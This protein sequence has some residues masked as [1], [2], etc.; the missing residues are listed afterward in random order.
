MRDHIFRRIWWV[1][2]GMGMLMPSITLGA[3]AY[4]PPSSRLWFYSQN[5]F[6]SRTDNFISQDKMKY[7]IASLGSETQLYTGAYMTKDTRTDTNLIYNDNYV[8]PLFGLGWRSPHLRMGAFIDLMYAFRTHSSKLDFRAAVYHY[9]FRLLGDSTWDSLTQWFFE[10][11]TDFSHLHNF[12]NNA[13]LQHWSKV[14]RRWYLTSAKHWR[15]D[16]FP[17]F[18]L[19]KDLQSWPY[20]SFVDVRVGLR[21]EYVFSSNLASMTVTRGTGLYAGD[22]YF[23][24]PF[25]ILLVLG[26]GLD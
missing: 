4:Q 26:L 21:L 19:N 20:S 9:D 3:D 18:I 5:L 10:T 17:E 14:G 8:A 15:A 6:D 13:F 2:A 1:A 7:R 11:Y 16:A 12:S 22:R 25:K 24:S 23:F